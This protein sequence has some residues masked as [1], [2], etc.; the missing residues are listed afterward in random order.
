MS[1]VRGGGW[2]GA[3]RLVWGRARV[4]AWGLAFVARGGRSVTSGG[5]VLLD[6]ARGAAV[7]TS[8]VPRLTSDVRHLVEATR[9][10]V[11]GQFDFA[12]TVTHA[13]LSRLPRVLDEPIQWRRN[14]A[15]LRT[16]LT[17]DE[18][19]NVRKA[20]RVL[21]IRHGGKTLSPKRRES[22]LRGLTAGEIDRG[23]ARRRRPLRV[24]CG[25]R[26]GRGHP[27]R[28]PRRGLMPHAWAGPGAGVT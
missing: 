17:P 28:V 13:H 5:G 7:R 22:R 4:R 6:R 9:W 1:P 15:I 12:G 24:T 18:H 23:G 10:V 27:H 25:L 11:V 20:R 19:A 8:E 2:V 16:G 3:C 21:R 14:D 26:E